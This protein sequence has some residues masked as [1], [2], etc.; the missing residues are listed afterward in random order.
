MI[1][2]RSLTQAMARS[3]GFVDTSSERRRTGVLGDRRPWRC[4]AG[5]FAADPP[6]GGSRWIP[7]RVPPAAPRNVSVFPVIPA[8]AGIQILGPRFRG[9]DPFAVASGR[10]G[11][12][13]HD[14]ARV[15]PRLKVVPVSRAE[16]T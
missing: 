7:G 14:L 11:L 2:R 6:R 9:D 13:A 15:S 1:R 5:R 3:G 12:S 10:P 8:E 16:I 4:R